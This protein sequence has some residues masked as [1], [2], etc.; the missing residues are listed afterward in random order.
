[1]DLTSPQLEI[2][3]RQC[4]GSR[5]LLGDLL[6]REQLFHFAPVLPADYLLA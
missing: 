6:Q 5:E 1:V 4:E 3:A 2:D